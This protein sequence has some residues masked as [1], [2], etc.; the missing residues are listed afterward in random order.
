MRAL[1]IADAAGFLRYHDIPGALPARLYIHGLGCAGSSDWPHVVAAPPLAGRRSLL[2]DLLGYGFSDRPQAFSYTMEAHADTLTA[3]LDHLALKSVEVI[4]HSMGGSIAILL[5]SRRP[6]LV[7]RLVVAEPNLDPGPGFVSGRIAA[8][9]EASFVAG[10]HRDLVELFEAA[11][12]KG[13]MAPGSYVAS[14]RLAAPHALH[15]SA[16]S[17]IAERVRSYREILRSLP[18]PRAYLYGARS[19]GDLAGLAESGVAIHRIADA[20]HGMMEDNPQGFAEAVARSLAA[21]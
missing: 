21:G 6:D 1:R 7:A 20:G 8:A 5:A 15:R 9:P 2:V 16:T 19:T 10:G 4:G 17:L 11:V 18:S 3:L 13:D 12:R 14:L